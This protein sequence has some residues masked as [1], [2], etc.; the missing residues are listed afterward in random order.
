M[1]TGVFPSAPFGPVFPV[2]PLGPCTGTFS[3]V[4]GS[5]K[6]SPFTVK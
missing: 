1:N 2:S 3:S 4:S 5:F 6:G